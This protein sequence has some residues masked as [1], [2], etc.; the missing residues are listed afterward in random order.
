MDVPK[1]KTFSIVE[2]AFPWGLCVFALFCK[3]RDRK[4]RMKPSGTA[5]VL[6]AWE[7]YQFKFENKIVL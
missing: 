3:Y 1:S 6:N 4:K 2:C 5:C 7:I